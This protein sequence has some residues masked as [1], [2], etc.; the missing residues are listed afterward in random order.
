MCPPRPHFWKV[1]HVTS[2]PPVSSTV[3]AGWPAHHILDRWGKALQCCG[4]W[5][6]S[7]RKHGNNPPYEAWWA[8]LH[9]NHTLL[10]APVLLV[11]PV[12]L[13][14]L[15]QKQKKTQYP[16]VGGYWSTVTGKWGIRKSHATGAHGS[17]TG[18]LHPEPRWACWTLPELPQSFRPRVG[19]DLSLGTQ[20]SW[21]DLQYEQC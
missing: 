14:S 11:L 18:T 7:N 9:I 6:S 13:S 4:F 10:K 16:S 21:W 1:Q 20:R 17:Y 3:Q 8:T 19:A 2:S 5:C 15:L 12:Y